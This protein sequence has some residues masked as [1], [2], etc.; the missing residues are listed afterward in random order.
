[1]AAPNHPSISKDD[2]VFKTQNQ[3]QA[4]PPGGKPETTYKEK[5]K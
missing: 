1:M 4:G 3:T 2:L 5:I